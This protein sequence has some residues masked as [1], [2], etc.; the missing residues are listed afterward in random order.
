MAATKKG[1]KM[2][3]GHMGKSLEV[4]EKNV[5][6]LLAYNYMCYLNV[7][8]LKLGFIRASFVSLCL[9]ISI[10]TLLVSTNS[11]V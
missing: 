6:G 2:V 8:F 4:E 5:L 11:E 1:N 3:I 10:L 7:F 9:F